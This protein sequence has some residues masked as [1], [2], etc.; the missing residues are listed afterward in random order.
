[1]HT[2][3]TILPQV[4]LFG[5]FAVWLPLQKG[6]SFLDPVILGA[7]AS[8]GVVFAAPAAA[9]GISVYKSIR[10][11]LGLSWAML[12]TGVAT[13]Y[14]TRTVAVGP[15]LESLAECG[16]F[17]LALSA[18]VSSVVVFTA[19]RASAAVAK[20]VA[21]LLLLT[22]LVLFFFRSGWLPDVALWGAAVCAGIAAIFFL[23]LHRQT[24]P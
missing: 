3:R 18:A 23:L 4:V 14:F 8:L 12:V 1:M 17:G 13:V 6:I 2:L 16:L 10:N 5:V 24:E 21:R 19:A 11:G 20:I 22:L 15:N 7:Y 9:S